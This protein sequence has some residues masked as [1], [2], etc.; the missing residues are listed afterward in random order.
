VDHVNLDA[1]LA[2]GGLER[3]FQ[4]EVYR[5]VEEALAAVGP[6]CSLSASLEADRFEVCV[7]VSCLARTLRPD[8]LDS[9]EARLDLIGGSLA[10]SSRAL[11]I[12]MPVPGARPIAA[13][14]QSRRV[15]TTDGARSSLP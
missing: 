1:S 2:T 4:T 3:V 10:H 7:S 15:E 9:L 6:D 8:A 11:T 14:P 13:F 5:A 12:R